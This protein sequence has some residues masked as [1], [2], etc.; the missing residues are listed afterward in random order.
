MKKNIK[1]LTAILMILIAVI[2]Y[3]LPLLLNLDKA[4]DFPK[5]NFVNGFYDIYYCAMMYRY[6]LLEEGQLL[7][8]WPFR[9]GGLYVLMHP[10]FIGVSPFSIFI[11]LLG[12]IK[13]VNFIYAISYLIAGISMFYL[14]RMVLKYDIYGAVY[15]SLVFAMCGFFPFMQFN[16]FIY[17]RETVFLP[18]ITAMYL[19]AEYSNK[20]S[21]LTAV[22]LSVF[23]F[24]TGIYFLVILLFLFIFSCVNSQS[25][26]NDKLYFSH[27]F[28]IIFLT[29]I[30]FTLIFS[31]PKIS[32][33]PQLIDANYEPLNTVYY[34]ES[35]LSVNH[36]ANNINLFFTHLLVPGMTGLGTMYTGILPVFLC[37]ISFVIFFKKNLKWLIIL[38]IFIVLSFGPNSLLDLHYWV[39]KIP[40]FKYMIEISKY[41][42]LIIVFIISIISGA[43]F[44]LLKS[45][46]SKKNRNIIAITLCLLTYGNLLWANIGYFS[47]YNKKIMLEKKL[48][49]GNF[50]SARCIN[51]HRR[52]EGGFVLLFNAL[53]LKGI[54][55]HNF[56]YRSTGTFRSDYL[57]S[58]YF[59]IPRFVFLQPST[60]IMILKNP[61]YNGEV[62]FL[63]KSNLVK[64]FSIKPNSVHLKIEVIEPDILIINQNYSKYWMSQEG[65][66]INYK[67]LLALAIN[68]KGEYEVTIKYVPIEFYLGSIIS[69]I[70]L[71]LFGIYFLKRKK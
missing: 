47:V 4:F 8:W 53:F 11:L 61:A 28:F 22:I 64:Y 36:A 9:E 6:S 14:T 17:A 13:G 52:D 1:N 67:G 69:L 62:N 18:L 26:K 68:K 23:I 39:Q 48:S 45:N 42:A 58:K 49:S 56:M 21:Y 41:Y 54:G 35:I 7:F 60:E 34:P 10:A 12:V 50:S 20:Y 30:F 3:L 38:I 32:P 63:S 70:F 29:I 2:I 51:M 40:L 16:G 19:K 15:S 25:E 37:I 65:N 44:K 66:V 57:E 55:A 24:S 59:V 43:F 33:V 71:M 46:F 5:K 27:R 31:L